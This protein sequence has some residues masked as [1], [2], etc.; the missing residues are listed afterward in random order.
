[1]IRISGILYTFLIFVLLIPKTYGQSKHKVLE[2]HYKAQQQ[3][4]WD[5]INTIS[6]K[7]EWGSVLGTFHGDFI[8]KK[9]NKIM[10]KSVKSRV[11]EAFDGKESWTIASWTDEE[12]LPMES[13]RS[14]MIRELMIFG[15][16][17]VDN[18]D[19]VFRGTASVDQIYC[20]W[21]E[22]IKSNRRVEYF[23]DIKTHMLYKSVITQKIGDETIALT[24]TVDKYRQFNGIQFPTIIRV[25][26]L[27]MESEY[28]FDSIVLGEGIPSSRFTKPDEL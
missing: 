15:S 27:E 21:F 12:V 6:A 22:V 2:K 14:F 24:R 20:Y 7:V 16:P 26:T 5:Q 25:K 4:F 13:Y 17:I 23:I 10:F 8:A 11:I 3:E 1:M 9:P 18:D 28:V 19:L